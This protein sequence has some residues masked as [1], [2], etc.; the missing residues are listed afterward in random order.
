LSPLEAHASPDDPSAAAGS[1][2]LSP[3]NAVALELALWES[4]KDGGAAELESYLEQ[5]PDGTFASLAQTRIA[6]AALSPRGEPA[7]PTPAQAAVD[8]LD[9][10][11]WESVKD[12]D[13]PEELQAY[14]KQHPNG[15]F[16][17]LARARLSSAQG[18]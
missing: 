8:A 15:H 11:F 5:Y 14:L 7:E 2:E 9:L 4:V 6:A 16:V 10:T 3:E 12:S 18:R 17:E 1:A 13:R